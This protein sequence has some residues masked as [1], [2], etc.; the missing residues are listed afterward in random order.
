MDGK[1]LSGFL[2]EKSEKL[3]DDEIKPFKESIVNELLLVPNTLAERAGQF[4]TAAD[5]YD[6]RFSIRSDIAEAVKKITADDLKAFIKNTYFAEKKGQIVFYYSGKG[7][8][9]KSQKLPGETFDDAHKIKE[10]DIVN[11]YVKK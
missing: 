3:T 10:W 2:K 6:G 7:S 11:P 1:K 4:F 5:K 8:K 9:V